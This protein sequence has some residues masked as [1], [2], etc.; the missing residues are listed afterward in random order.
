MAGW[1]R[2]GAALAD[3]DARL[4]DMRAATSALESDVDALE[5]EAAAS[6]ERASYA[7]RIERQHQ[8]AKS[9]VAELEDELAALHADL[10]ARQVRIAELEAAAAP[11]AQ[12]APVVPAAPAPA[13]APST[14]HPGSF[15]SAAG[16]TGVTVKGTA[17]VCTTTASDARLRWRAA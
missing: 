8:T 9:R 13:P 7:D 1:A 15:C 6:A 3:R 10:D 2:T 11:A 17:M 4:S 14:V 12:A 5:L 16:A